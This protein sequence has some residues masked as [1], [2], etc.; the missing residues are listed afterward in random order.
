MSSE[1]EPVHELHEAKQKT[2]E[3]MKSAPRLSMISRVCGMLGGPLWGTGMLAIV[4]SVAGAAS[5]GTIPLMYAVGMTVL[6]GA[7]SLASIAI[8]YTSTRKM[9]SHGFDQMELSCKTNA[10][11]LVKELKTNGV[12]FGVTSPAASMEFDN[13]PRTDGRKWVEVVTPQNSM[14]ENAVANTNSVMNR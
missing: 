14:L 9:Q 7:L 3:K 2:F 8:D 13:A 1:K 6:G 11:H 5:G 4:M 10:H 12:M